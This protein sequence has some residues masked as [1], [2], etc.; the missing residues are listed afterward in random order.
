MKIAMVSE[1]ADPTAALGGADAGGQNVYVASLSAALA[2]RGHEITVYTR[3][4]C[5]SAPERTGLCPGVTV[6]RVKAGPPRKVPKDQ[7]LPHMAEF[8]D[9]LGELWQQSPPDVAHAHFWMSGVATLRA[10]AGLPL[11]VAQTFHALGTVKR[12]FQGSAD[13]SPPARIKL[14]TDVGR[15][16]DQI[17]ATCSDEVTELTRM[18]LDQARISVVPCGV[19]ARHFTPDGAAYPRASRPRLLTLGRLVPRKGVDTIIEALAQVRGAELLVAGGPPRSELAGDPEV[20]RLSEVARA[21]GVAGRVIFTGGLSHTDIPRLLRSADVVICTPWYEP[22]GIVPLEAMA[23]GV[24]VVA[25]AIGGLTDTVVHG[26]TGLHV[27][28]RDP[29]AVAEAVKLLLAG[30]AMRASFGRA[31]VRR[32]R[33]WYEWGRVAAQ[34]EA[35]YARL[36]G[37]ASG[38]PGGQPSEDAVGS[39]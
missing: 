3:R 34:T 22:F 38:L 24:P 20:A 23:C 29:A 7:L 39:R 31:G 12:R 17:I 25:S 36:A 11:P 28:P 14:E 19:S 1:H 15:R 2:R 6:R 5:A 26:E 21:H 30:P 33:R 16:A 35:V 13:T 27:P 9:G 4:E 10:A 8:G 18:G 32:V 37:A